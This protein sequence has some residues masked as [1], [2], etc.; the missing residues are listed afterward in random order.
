[1]TYKVLT[2]N[3]I[4]QQQWQELIQSSP[5]ATWFQTDEAYR[6]YQSVCGM[7]AFAYGVSEQGKLVGVVVGYITQ[8]RCSMKQFFTRRAIIYGG[9]LLAE[10]I[11]ETAL[12]ELLKAV[13]ECRVESVECRAKDTSGAVTPA[14]TPYTK[15]MIKILTYDQIDQQQW[16]KLIEASATATWFQTPEAYRFYQSVGGMQ[17]FAYGVSEE[18]RL[19]GV[20]VGYITKEKNPIKQFFTR[21]AIIYGG[22]LLAED[23]SD[24]A[25]SAL[26]TSLT[27]LPSL[28]GGG[29][30][31]LT[32]IYIESR[33][34]HD[35]SRW[36]SV[37][38]AN[39]FAYK[40]HLNFHINTTSLDLAQSNIGKHRWK[41]IRLS[42]RDGA[43]IVENPTIE[44]VR[45]FYTI[46]QDLYRTKVKTPLWSWEF[47]EQLY[48]VQH[49]KYILVELDGKIVGGTVCVCLPGK[50]V[51]EW[52]TC[53]LDNCRDDIRPLSVAIWGEMQYAAE[54]GYPLFD[55]M[56]AG[57]PDEPYGVR[58]FKAEF[59]G[60]LVEHG[61]FLCIRKP[62]LYWIGKMGVKWLKRRK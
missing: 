14:H 58:D 29:G 30:G 13:S 56:G 39:G 44:Q 31:R 49:A 37:F 34:F 43:K 8:E 36:R 62:L 26:L 10:D 40:K 48:R 57:K 52:Y 28:Q 47:F 1:M 27:K 45:A 33:N 11:C 9:P 16:Q 53:G 41:Y 51:Y 15:T 6:L 3:Q 32:P 38:E 61:R 25:L 19:V 18:D 42:M 35:Y 59:G 55:F 5:V 24:E 7:Q 17:A 20:V 50:A 46:L 60:E 23:I 12:A 4:A 21:R 2:Y 54:N 22:P